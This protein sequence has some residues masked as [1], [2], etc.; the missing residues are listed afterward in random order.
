MDYNDILYYLHLDSSIVSHQ[1]ELDELFAKANRIKLANRG[2]KVFFRGLI[3]VSNICNKDCFY[4]GIRKSNLNVSRYQLQ[5]DIILKEAQFALDS[6]YGSVVLQAGERVDDN[7]R[8]LIT[9]VI[10]DIKRLKSTKGTF[11][12]KTSS[13]G[14]TL[15]LGEQPIDVYKEWYDAG[16]HRYL[17]RIESS[18]KNFYNSLHPNDGNHLFNHRLEAIS[19]LQKVGFKTGTG[20]MIGVPGQKL[21]DLANDLLF[22]KEIN[23]GMVGMGPFIPHT[24]TPM[25]NVVSEFSDS[26][27]LSLTL[28]MVALLRILM[29]HIN[30]AATTALQVLEP[31]ARERA[32][33]CG[34]NVI[35]PNITDVGVK[36]N[37]NLYEGKPG[38]KDDAISTKNNLLSALEAIGVCVGWNELGD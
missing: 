22:F 21:E 23:I 38:L 27:K 16:A 18:N 19:N 36:A 34:A 11:G 7:F 13:L 37:Y 1:Q 14:I 2:N 17:L 24:Q 15:S 20:V 3:E 10:K 30:I 35:M 33:L 25:G 4:C 12:E 26:Q 9:R 6:G 28:R 29:P 32:I 5:E 31:N 8:H